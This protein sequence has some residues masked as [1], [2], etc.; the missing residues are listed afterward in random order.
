MVT[1]WDTLATDSLGKPVRR[2]DNATFP[3]DEAHFIWVVNGT[4]TTVRMLLRLKA[5]D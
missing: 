1:I 4:Q 2:F 3:G 5:S